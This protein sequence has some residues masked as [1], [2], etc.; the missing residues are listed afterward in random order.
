MVRLLRFSLM[1]IMLIL[2]VSSCK[3]KQKI[4]E[5]RTEEIVKKQSDSMDVACKNNLE[6]INT[7]DKQN[8]VLDE[9]DST[10][11]KFREHLVIDFSGNVVLREI[12]HQKE[13]YKAKGR[14]HRNNREI[15][16]L[17]A[18]KQEQMTYEQYLDGIYNASLQNVEEE[19]EPSSSR[20]LWLIGFLTL[21]TMVGAI[22]S[23]IVK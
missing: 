2:A 6:A 4:T 10:V 3:T 22:I 9:R 23:K 20:W 11:E 1:S 17:E 14:I 18:A 19:S 13:K 7:H 15:Q 16:H 8:T 12:E 21:L 5:T